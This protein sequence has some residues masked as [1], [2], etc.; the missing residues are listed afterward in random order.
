M[1]LAQT[2]NRLSKIATG[3]LTPG[4]PSPLNIE[5]TGEY[6]VFFRISNALAAIA[7]ASTKGA[8]QTAINRPF[9]DKIDEVVRGTLENAG[10][11]LDI[12]SRPGIIYISWK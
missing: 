1:N 2:A 3:K 10:F 4:R 11:K 8:C 6:D 5:K 9:A 7:I 12:D